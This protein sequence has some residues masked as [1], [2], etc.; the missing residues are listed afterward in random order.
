MDIEIKIPKT[1]K[2]YTPSV[3][4][5]LTKLGYFDDV[6]EINNKS[7]MIFGNV[8][9]TGVKQVKEDFSY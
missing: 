1:F 7:H 5:K 6:D 4:K 8:P 3:M 2:R 9:H